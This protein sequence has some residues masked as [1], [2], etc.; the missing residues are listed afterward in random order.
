MEEAF[1][2]CCFA[3]GESQMSLSCNSP[4]ITIIVVSDAC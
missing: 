2:I 1:V 4:L 3:L